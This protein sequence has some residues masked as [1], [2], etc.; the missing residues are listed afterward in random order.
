MTVTVTRNPPPKELGYVTA[1]VGF[2]SRACG[3]RV[4]YGCGLV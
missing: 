3:K 2:T 4:K 1:E